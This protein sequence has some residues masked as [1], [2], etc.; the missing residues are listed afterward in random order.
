MNTCLSKNNPNQTA[1]TT[2]TNKIQVGPCYEAFGKF[3]SDVLIPN[4]DSL[5][6]H[7]M[8]PKMS[9]HELDNLWQFLWPSKL[10]QL[11]SLAAKRSHQRPQQLIH[12][13]LSQCPHKNSRT[14]QIIVKKFPCKAICRPSCPLATPAPF[15]IWSI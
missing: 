7:R 11:S 5:P 13:S 2:A 10:G 12:N 15:S 6:T 9:I 1:A 14:H 4:I 3:A 8:S